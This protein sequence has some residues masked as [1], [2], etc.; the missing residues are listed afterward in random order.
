MSASI[1]KKMNSNLKLNTVFAFMACDGNI[2][3]EEMQLMYT[4]CG[5]EVNEDKLKA[6]VADL[7]A[8]GSAWLDQ[9]VSEVASASLGKTDALELL[10]VAVDTIL[11]DNE[12]EYHEVRF[13]RR[14]R[15][16]LDA[17][18][19]DEILAADP[20]VEEYWLEPD[21]APSANSSINFSEIKIPALS[22]A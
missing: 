14:V 20:R 4:L 6:M 3:P 18:T 19:D 15:G 7:N 12:L 9:Y 10:R 1:L 5:D 2:A 17:V 22:K 8:R 13:L 21:L 16:C 11:A